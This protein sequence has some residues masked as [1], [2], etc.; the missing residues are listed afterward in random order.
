MEDTVFKLVYC[1]AYELTEEETVDTNSAG[2]AYIG[3]LCFSIQKGMAPE[4]GMKLASFVAAVKCKR[5]GEM[6]DCIP[7][8]SEVEKY[9]ETH[10]K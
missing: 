2:D 9:I 10:C 6:A 8:L 5:A 4:K 7:P 3:A 1:P